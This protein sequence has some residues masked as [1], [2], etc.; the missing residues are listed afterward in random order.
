MKETKYCPI[1]CHLLSLCSVYY[2][3]R[4]KGSRMKKREYVSTGNKR[5]EGTKD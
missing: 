5:L 4:N 1:T 3:Q 2:P